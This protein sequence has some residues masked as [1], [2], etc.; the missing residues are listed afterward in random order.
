M[1]FSLS[2]T[3]VGPSANT[4]AEVS[5]TQAHKGVCSEFFDMARAYSLPAASRCHRAT[6]RTGL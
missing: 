2:S 3:F 1:E 5:S 4:D 6:D